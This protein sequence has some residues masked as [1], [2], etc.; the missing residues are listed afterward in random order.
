MVRLAISLMDANKHLEAL[1]AIY[2][3]DGLR[4]DGEANHIP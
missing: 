2:T 4:R 1:S 3:I